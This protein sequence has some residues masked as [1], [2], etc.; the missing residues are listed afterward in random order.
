MDRRTRSF[1][2]ASDAMIAGDWDGDESESVGVVRFG[3]WFLKN[4]NTTGTSDS[5]FRYGHWRGD[6]FLVWGESTT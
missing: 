1:F 4:E 2:S 6:I 5:H 3:T